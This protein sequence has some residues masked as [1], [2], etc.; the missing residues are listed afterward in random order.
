M[1]APEIPLRVLLWQE[2]WLGKILKARIKDVQLLRERSRH[3]LHTENSFLSSPPRSSFSN[4]LIQPLCLINLH[5]A[6]RLYDTSGY[7]KPVVTK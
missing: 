4:I 6:I 1:S 7:V 5:S 3:L 2:L